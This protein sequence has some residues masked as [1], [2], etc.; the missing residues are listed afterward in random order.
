MQCVFYCRGEIPTCD[1]RVGGVHL[2]SGSEAHA[3]PTLAL[4]LVGVREGSMST[5]R[6]QE[7]LEKPNVREVGEAKG[8]V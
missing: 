2:V 3:H 7:T 8:T 1:Y 4:S 5:E 6:W